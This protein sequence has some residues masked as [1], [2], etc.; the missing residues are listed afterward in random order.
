M[1]NKKLFYNLT[2][3]ITYINVFTQDHSFSLL[4]CTMLED[5]KFLF[6]MRKAVRKHKKTKVQGKRLNKMK[7]PK[8]LFQTSL[9]GE[10]QIIMM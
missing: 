2:K 1:L 4:N 8:A 10:I 3:H 9:V 5:S 6:K 7:F